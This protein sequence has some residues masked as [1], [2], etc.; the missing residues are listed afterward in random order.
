M[1]DITHLEYR[2]ILQSYSSADMY[3]EYPD[4]TYKTVSAPKCSYLGVQEILSSSIFASCES[5]ACAIHV[6]NGGCDKIP[7]KQ[8]AVCNVHNTWT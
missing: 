5:A 7:A 2:R 3:R 4:I 6:A 1:A 8:E